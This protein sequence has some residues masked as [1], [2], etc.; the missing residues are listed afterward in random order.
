MIRKQD[1]ENRG[2]V[3]RRLQP[4]VVC[5]C[6]STRFKDEFVEQNRLLTMDGKI[7]LAPGVF[8]HSGDPLTDADKERLDKLHLWKITKA[9]SVL[10]INPG[11]YIGD[12][13]RREIN[14]AESIGKPI[15]FTHNNPISGA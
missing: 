2:D 15:S 8:G 4:L 11:G 14:F 9:D 5:L 7:V 1:V 3:P 12:S 13:T 6:G 10:V